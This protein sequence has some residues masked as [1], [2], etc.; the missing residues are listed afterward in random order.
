MTQSSLAQQ[1]SDELA[2]AVEH[3]APRVV[4]SRGRRGRA[5][6]G[7]ILDARSVVVSDH[8]IDG[9]E[10]IPLRTASGDVEGRLVGRDAG[11]DLALLDVAEGLPG[12]PP[13]A[14]ASARTG[15]LVIA[16]GRSFSGVV[17]HPGFVTGESGPHH[18]SPGF[19]LARIP[20][21]SIAPFSGFSGGA[22]VNVRGE[23]IGV[24]SSG[25][26]RGHGLAV[27]G[28]DV[29]R[30]VDALR[31]HGRLRRGYLGV[32]SIPVTLAGLQRAE[33]GSE[34]GLLVTS[35]APDSPADAARILVGDVITALDGQA[36]RRPD[37]V[38]AYLTA[39]RVGRTASVSLVR[40][41]QAFQVEATIAERGG[42]Q[43]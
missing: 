33:S 37:D 42:D 40:G 2:H 34:R 12:A 9:D 11:T 22:I 36:V 16:V 10:Q 20:H 4:F 29:A 41:T 32:T 15:D 17:A 14:H 35:V 18:V 26:L 31:R 19:T 21:T 23:L 7:T 3:V 24:A 38:V 25:L 27:P 39:E 8:L 6:T 30:V 1:L 13:L 28:L 5:A 43:R